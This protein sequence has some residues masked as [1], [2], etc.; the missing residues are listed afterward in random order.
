MTFERW[1][2]IDWGVSQWKMLQAKEARYA[3]TWRS[4]CAW[5]SLILKTLW[6]L[7]FGRMS[8]WVAK[9]EKEADH[10]G[11]AV[12]PSDLT[13]TWR[14]R[15]TSERGVCVCVCVFS[16]KREVTWSDVHFWEP[17]WVVHIGTRLRKIVN[18][19]RDRSFWSLFYV[20]AMGIQKIKAKNDG[21]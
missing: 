16:L 10:R 14:Q 21:A 1:L 7:G 3:E 13:T 6:K 11:F 17:T 19:L 18:S 2:N 4:G 12:L 9:L 20:N 15:E 5:G 8:C